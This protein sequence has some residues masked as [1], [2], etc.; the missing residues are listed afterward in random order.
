MDRSLKRYLRS[1][2]DQA[3]P[4]V[5]KTEDIYYDEVNLYLIQ[6]YAGQGDLYKLL[7]KKKS[8]TES[9][10]IE[11]FYEFLCVISAAHEL[12]LIIRNLKPS[13]ILFHTGLFDNEKIQIALAD[14]GL[15]ELNRSGDPYFTDYKQYMSPELVYGQLDQLSTKTDI[16]SV[17]TILYFMVTFKVINIYK[18]LSRES[19]N[20]AQVIEEQFRFE[21]PNWKSISEEFK[22]LIQSCLR[23]DSTTRPSAQDLLQNPIF[24]SRNQ[25]KEGLLNQDPN[26]LKNVQE[27]LLKFQN[28]NELKQIIMRFMSIQDQK[29]EDE[30]RTRQLFE[31]LEN[32]NKGYIS[33]PVLAD[34]LAGSYGIVTARNIVHSID[35]DK[36]GRIQYSEFRAAVLKTSLQEKEHLVF[37]AYNQLDANKDGKLSAK[38]LVDG[39]I[40]GSEIYSRYEEEFRAMS[41]EV[42]QKFDNNNDGHLDRE[43]FKNYIF[44]HFKNAKN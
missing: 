42:L 34:Y 31:A 40:L 43:E 36:D 22:A 35:A 39:L 25:R 21:E 24:Q 3:H 30:D 15:S 4:N 26:L 13:N 5:L 20:I 10:L 1:Q 9:D 6:E 38:E 14:V 19:Q 23:A 28:A 29:F 41:N 12:N 18:H 27:D 33:K 32:S 44:D 16:W 17:G 2:R 8:L 11:I 37:S 7:Q